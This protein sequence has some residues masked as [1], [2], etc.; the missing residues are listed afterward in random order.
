MAR[1]KPLELRFAQVTEAFRF[2]ESRLLGGLLL[3]SAR[4]CDS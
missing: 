4:T 2:K 1:E 3:N